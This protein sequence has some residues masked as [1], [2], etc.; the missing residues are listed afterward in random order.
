M[1]GRE[2]LVAITGITTWIAVQA[3]LNIGGITSI[4][5]LT[6]VPL[7]FLSYGSNALT[8]VLLAM[9]ILISISRYQPGVNYRQSAPVQ[10][11]RRIVKRVKR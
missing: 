8:A 3:L 5:P 9:G 1:H 2:E 6:G 7:P 11:V 4:I 10:H